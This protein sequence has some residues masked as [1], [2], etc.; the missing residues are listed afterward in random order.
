VNPEWEKRISDEVERIAEVLTQRLIEADKITT[1][2]D[3]LDGDWSLNDL[4]LLHEW[5]ID[6][7]SVS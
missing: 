1:Y 2:S 4:A 7:R 3:R 5:G 6:V